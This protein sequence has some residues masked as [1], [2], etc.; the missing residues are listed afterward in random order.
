M[1]M[2]L[3]DRRPVL[4]PLLGLALVAGS[5]NGIARAQEV[6]FY[7]DTVLRTLRLEF[8]QSDWWDQLRQNYGT[9]VYVEADLIVDG[10]TY[11]QVGVKFK[12]YS[13]YLFSDG[14]KKPFKIKLDAFVPGQELYGY[15]SIRLNNCWTDP[16]FVREPVMYNL[17]RDYCPG[18]RCNFVVLEIN[19]ENWGVYVNDQQKDRK[20]MSQWYLAD[21]GN[22][23]KLTEFGGNLLYY[24]TDWRDYDR[25]YDSQADDNP[26]PWNDLIHFCD[27]LN[28]TT[29]GETLT[30]ALRPICDLDGTM[31]MLAVNNVFSN[32]DSYQEWGNN[33]YVYHDDYHDRM[34]VMIH[35]L[36]MSF[37]TL[38]V[39]A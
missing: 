2:F 16:T 26:D 27:V 17:L 10:V 25:Y 6:D 4:A 31:W 9:D 22:R 3:R 18:S 30:D 13:S 28:N 5:M 34:E 12:G 14:E 24:G 33:F 11:P 8:A 37:G 29:V 7:D 21:T 15:D 35:D 1:S 36:N 39:A 23:Y 38:V 19:G 32:M 20:Y